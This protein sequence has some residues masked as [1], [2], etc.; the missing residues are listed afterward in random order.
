MAGNFDQ[1]LSRFSLSVSSPN[2]TE[3]RAARQA[4]A[5]NW[6]CCYCG[7]RMFAGHPAEDIYLYCSS[8]GMW[9]VYKGEPD[10]WVFMQLSNLKVS[11]EHV[12]DSF[13]RSGGHGQECLA[14]CCLCN[15]WRGG[16]ANGRGW[17]MQPSPAV[18][19]RVMQRKI[20]AGT[21]PH[22]PYL[23]HA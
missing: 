18:W 13:M 5:Q 21:H 10:M 16:K 3:R 22:C 8:M 9:P 4:E 14:A 12:K 2:W 20:A 17:R 15:S 7:V 1:M 19:W 23:A 6:R 11:L